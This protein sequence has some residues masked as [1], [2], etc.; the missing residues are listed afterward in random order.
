MLRVESVVK[1]Y[2]LRRGVFGGSSGTLRAVDGV[3]LEI[4]EGSTFGLVGE[5]GCG[6][7]TLS[8]IVL[9]LEAPTSGSIEAAGRDPQNLD[10]A[11]LKAWRRDVQIIA[12]DPAGA[13]PVRMRA[14]RLV[15]EPWRIHGVT[16]SGGRGSRALDLLRR[17]G[18]N[19]RQARAFPHQLS[20]GQRQRVVIAR[21]IALEPRLV[22][23]DE[24]VSA[25]DVSVQAQVLDLLRDLQAESRLTYLFISHDLGVVRSMASEIGVMFAGRMVERGPAA[26]LYDRPAHPYTRE[27]LDAM[28]SIRAAGRPRRAAS[29]PAA[30][31]S[32]DAHAI[33]CAYRARCPLAIDRCTTERPAVRGVAPGRSAACHRAED[34]LARP[35]NTALEN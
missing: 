23:C 8:R 30:S 33:G 6:K 9:G 18:L 24:P 16:P 35:P 26:A 15:E 12:Q 10:R 5:S 13:L 17:V 2:P 7:S 25:L 32:A 4:A 29:L 22:V 14:A 20:G 1:D 31:L 28:P 27:L 34:M 11:A 21:A 19:E 3:S